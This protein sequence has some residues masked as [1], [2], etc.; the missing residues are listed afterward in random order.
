M[1]SPPSPWPS[2]LLRLAV[3]SLLACWVTWPVPLQLG[4]SVPGAGRSDLGNSLWSLWFVEHELSSGALPWRTS[5][6]GWPDG[7]VLLVADPLNALIGLPLVAAFGLLAA[8]SL[9]CMGHVVFSGLAAHALGLYMWGDRR[10]AWV[11][12]VGFALAPVLISGM[13]NGT[14]EAIAGG[15]L[16]LSV[17]A[18]LK[19]LDRGGAGR[20][21]FAGICLFLAALSSWYIGICAW[22]FWAAFLFAARPSV[23]RGRRLGRSAVVAA[24]S[25]AFTLPWAAASHAGVQDPDNLVGIKHE[26]ELDT[27]R[28]SIGPADPRGWFLPGDFR[29]PDFSDLSR[30]GE[31]FVHC[32][33]LG[34]VLMLAAGAGFV[35]GKR[36]R[37][38]GALAVAGLG[39]LVLAMGPV[40]CIDGTAWVI[41]RRL[42]V[43]LPYFIIEDL[44]GFSA[45]SLLYRLGAAASLALA[46]LAAGA[47][48]GLPQTWLAPVLAGLVALEF[49]IAA[50][51]HGLPDTSRMVLDPAFD[52]LAKAPEGAVVNYP[53]AGGRSYLYEQSVHH[54]PLTGSLNFPNNSASRSL[55]AAMLKDAA[56]KN[57][58]QPLESTRRV[59]RKQKIRYLVIHQDES[60][61]PDMHDQA[62][63]ALDAAQ[64][65]LAEGQGVR[66]HAL[67]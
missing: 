26:K 47:I 38:R 28:R 39:G 25:L 9:I 13:Q 66:I 48:R 14:S 21:L 50:P 22:L 34:W 56:G 20:V 37:G 61:R 59:A 46:M 17:L 36:G 55:W 31:E 67:W 60:A 65:P 45:L 40:V 29:S 23:S 12:G 7:G 33:Y 52:V 16:P 35:R 18:L 1:T 44:P 57:V 42:A 51:V 8:Y 4:Q 63:R 6:L 32:H 11:T 41:D 58:K 19:A 54:K 2:R 10:A 49:R 27:V 5:L 64:E 24:L 53:V 30:Y 15:W 3:Y 43:P 62:V